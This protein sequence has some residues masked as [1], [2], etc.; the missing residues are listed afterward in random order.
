MSTCPCLRSLTGI[1]NLC[2]VLCSAAPLETNMQADTFVGGASG[3]GPFP[4]IHALRC[5]F[6]RAGKNLTFSPSSSSYSSSSSG[7]SS[8]HRSPL[9][10]S[11]PRICVGTEL[12]AS[13]GGQS[14]NVRGT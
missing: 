3:R 10:P 8:A 6:I 13:D 4:V 7:F 14:K 5:G 11:A 9:F 12:N 1:K 2:L